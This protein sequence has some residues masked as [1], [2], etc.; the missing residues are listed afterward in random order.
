LDV[1]DTV[2]LRRAAGER[3]FVRTNRV[4]SR[5]ARQYRRNRPPGAG[6][7]WRA[8]R[9]ARGCEGRKDRIPA[10]LRRCAPRSTRPGN[11]GDAVQHWLHQQAVHGCGDTHAGG[12]RQALARRS[13]IEIHFW[14]YAGKRGH[15]SRVTVP[16]IRVPG[17]LAAGLRDAH[18]VEARYPRRDSRS[19]GPHPPRFRARHQVAVQ[20]HELRYRGSHR[21]EGQQHA[22][23]GVAGSTSVHTSGN[24]EH[25]RHE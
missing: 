2:R 9:F 12:G 8:Q 21:R 20:Q 24:E 10:S 6:D 3:I 16:H 13:G 23:V 1:L 19:L 15:H 25:H 17:L 5:V 11:F 7:D 4:G 14:A 18:D 22:A